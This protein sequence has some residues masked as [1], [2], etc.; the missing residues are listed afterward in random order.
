[1]EKLLQHLARLGHHFLDGHAFVADDDALL[2]IALHINERTDAN[3]LFRLLKLLDHHLAGV[4]NLLIVV[5]KNLL[6]DDFRHE[7]ARRFVCPLVFLEVRRRIGKQL[8]DARQDAVD[9]EL[10][11]RRN[12]EDLGRGQDFFPRLDEFHDTRL[13][14][15]VD[16]VDQHQDRHLH[17][18]HLRDEV[19]VFVGLLHHIRHVEQHIGVLQRTFGEGEHRLLEFIVGFQH[20]RGVREDDLRIV[21]VDNAHN[22]VARGLRLEGCDRN[23]LAHEQIHERGF[24]DIGIADDIDET[25]FVHRLEKKSAAF[26]PKSRRVALCGEM[27]DA[28]TEITGRRS[29]TSCRLRPK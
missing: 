10:R 24:A 11:L 16:F 4:G 6:A 25:G 2:T 22:A 19:G 1:M 17:A 15:Q 27:C 18:L 7:K 12:R 9:S 29:P 20:A 21:G 8:F 13:I 5:Q 3:A 14:R 28:E 26:R 23:A